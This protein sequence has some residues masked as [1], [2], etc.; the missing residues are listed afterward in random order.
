MK[1]LYFTGTGNSLEVASHIA[2]RK[3]GELLS[4]P[5]LLT[6]ETYY[7]EDDVVGIVFPIYYISVPSLVDQYLKQLV[8]NSSYTFVIMTHANISLESKA[9]CQNYQFKVDYF[10]QLKMA[11]NYVPW[12]DLEKTNRRQPQYQKQLQDICHDISQRLPNNKFNRPKYHLGNIARRFNKTNPQSLD[13][14]FYVTD[15]C[16]KCKLCERVCV[17]N[18][19]EVSHTVDFKQNC[20]Q[21]MA[22]INLCPSNAIHHLKEKSNARYQNPNISIKQ[23]LDANSNNYN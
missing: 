4:I 10:Q 19:I 16:S 11:N 1:I 2:K 21:C 3:S 7:I 8:I 13:R 20:Q 17:T 6:D 15:D 5:K 18:N 12:F 22:C 9:L 23:L 14:N